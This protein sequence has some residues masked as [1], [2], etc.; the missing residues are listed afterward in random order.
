MRWIFVG[1]IEDHHLDFL[2]LEIAGHFFWPQFK[3]DHDM[4]IFLPGY[5]AADRRGLPR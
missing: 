5:R 2:D 3:T 1:L 4:L